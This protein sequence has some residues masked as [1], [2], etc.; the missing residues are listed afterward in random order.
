M[1]LVSYSAVSPRTLPLTEYNLRFFENL[2]LL[3]LSAVVPAINMLS[4][5]NARENDIN[6]VVNTFFI[7]YTLGYGAIFI[8]EI[9]V[10]TLVRLAVFCWLD[11]GIF[12]LAP[13]TPVP[14][15][16]WLL[17]ENRYRPKRIT[18]FAADLLTSC[19]AC[20]I[21]EEYAKLRLLEWTVN[22]PR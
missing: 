20:P 9:V 16:P 19:V 11:R 4:V 18:L 17:R 6:N 7:S 15:L 12:A 3:A 2:K 10:T 1:A 14:V 8:V 5:F 21:I 13:N 22:L